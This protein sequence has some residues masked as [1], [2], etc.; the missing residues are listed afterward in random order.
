MIP[1]RSAAV[2]HLKKSE[3]HGVRV[4]SISVSVV[5]HMR[6]KAENEKKNVKRKMFGWCWADDDET[7]FRAIATFSS[8]P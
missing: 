1:S 7:L 3:A 8:V 5:G 6:V 2:I 4:K